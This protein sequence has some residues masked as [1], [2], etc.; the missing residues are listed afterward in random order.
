M[1]LDATLVD[2]FAEGFR[3]RMRASR[4]PG[5]E[6]LDA[7]GIVALVGRGAEV[8]DGRFLVTDDRAAGLLRDRLPELHPRVANVFAGAVECV[9]LVADQ[10][11]YRPQ[12][13]TAMVRGD[14]CSVP[15]LDLPEG[16]ALRGASVHPSG[17]EVP[18]IDAAACAL[19]A[20]PNAAPTTDL[21]AFVA[22]LAA[23]PNARFLAAV[24]DEGHVRATSAAAV[25]GRNTGVFFVDT[26]APWRGRGVG[27]A[28]TAAA[29]RAAAANGAETACLDSSALG[30]PIYLRLGFREVSESTLF[31]RED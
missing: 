1:T 11:G 20:D 30:K 4:R 22:Y 6:L 5:Q 10:P 14:L 19:R 3:Q 8:A 27:T 24:D 12:P 31:V 2:T 7:P 29:L 9:R 16:L 25:Y 21:P 26:E 17:D 15:E 23:I 13:T 28:M 18:L